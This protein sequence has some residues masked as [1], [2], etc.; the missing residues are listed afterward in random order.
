[1]GLHLH[2]QALLFHGRHHGF[3]RVK[4][5]QT[6]KAAGF[7]VHAAVL[8]HHRDQRQTMALAD[9]EV[10]GVMGG[11]HLDAPGAELSI[12]VLIG[13]DRNLAPHQRQG[14]V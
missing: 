14:E 2:Q 6:G 4:A 12:N 11:R 10:V 9:G 7:T 3:A 5:I 13:H 8:G 1:M